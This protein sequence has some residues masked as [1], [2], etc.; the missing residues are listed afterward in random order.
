MKSSQADIGLYFIAVVPPEPV[1]Q[2]AQ[3]WKEHFASQYNSKA[4]L[5]SPPHITLHMPFKMKEK[6][7]QLLVDELRDAGSQ[8]QSLTLKING[9]D[10]FPPRVVFLNVV[11]HLSLNTLQ[12]G[13]AQV[14]K[15]KFNLFNADYRDRPFHPHL[16]LAFR[17]LKKDKFENAWAEFEQK[18]YNEE[19][20]LDRFWL[21]K[22]DGKRWKKFESFSL[23]KE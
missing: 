23:K 2:Q 7:V 16:T 4:S 21:L 13:I 22:H 9:F 1:Y 17:D 15:T 20:F 3:N 18:T 8:H 10:V 19:F 11:K 6:K 14:M 5:N 12:E